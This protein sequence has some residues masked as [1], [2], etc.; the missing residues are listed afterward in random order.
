[1][2][3][4]F[5]SETSAK[6]LALVAV[7]AK[8]WPAAT[9]AGPHLGTPLPHPLFRL[10]YQVEIRHHQIPSSKIRNLLTAADARTV[11]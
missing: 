4:C 1:L 8:P 7:C 3:C 10:F 6:A 9:I 5:R 11:Q 2:F